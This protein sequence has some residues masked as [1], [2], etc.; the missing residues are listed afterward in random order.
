MNK[1][2]SI[3]VIPVEWRFYAALFQPASRARLLF[4]VGLAA[5]QAAAA[6]PVVF[7]LRRIFDHAL[8]AG[9][10]RALS[11]AVA[12]V[13]TASLVQTG[14]ML[15]ARALT[16]D[17]VK[18][19]IARL[20]RDLV[21]RLLVLPRAF[22]LRADRGV[23]H[24]TVVQDTERLDDMSVVM[25]TQF[26]P[27]LVGSV[28]WV[29]VLAWLD[30]RLCLALLMLW[31]L[32]FFAVRRLRDW[33][34]ASVRAFHATFER[35][36]QS[37]LELLHRLDLTR[38]QAAESEET[39]SQHERIGALQRAGGAVAWAVTVHGAGY[40]IL[41]M[42]TGLVIL[43]I[44]GAAV[45]HGTLTVGA[46][47]S[48]FYIARALNAA[49]AQLVQLVPK[50]IAGQEA[51]GS[52]APLLADRS[53]AKNSP[54]T[55]PPYPKG[56]QPVHFAGSIEF[57]DVTFSY[58]TDVPD[59]GQHTPV[60]RGV[61]LQFRPG[62]IVALMGPNGA[63]K[64]TLLH[65]LLGFYRPTTG[66]IRADDQP[67]ASLDLARLRARLGV[68]PQSPLFFRGTVR[69]N[70]VY[71][72]PEAG[73]EDVRNALERAGAAEFV[74]A[75]PQGLETLIGDDGT[76]L[77]GGQRQRLALARALLRKPA[78]L[79]LDEPTTHLDAVAVDRLVDTLRAAERR[80][81]VLLIS[82]DHDLIARCCADR[83]YELRSGRLRPVQPAAEF[84]ARGRMQPDTP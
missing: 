38:Q 64:S 29:G 82:H 4:C 16:L 81:T 35:Y 54:F 22:H 37:T 48:A 66:E 69:E 6:W 55:A 63:G 44:G 3:F 10:L 26:V 68:V 49:Q 5:A 8:P 27:A 53:A 59:D 14:L 23:L 80:P 76:R 36:S 73:P 31:P 30:W 57:R 18:Q 56:G 12:G 33:M 40:E 67:Y 77:S 45:I 24:A 58:P 7:L 17:V 15:G 19:V 83:V 61:S 60:L 78:L 39:A 21:D 20:R 71:G 47:V 42:L 34:R 50:L 28:G 11:L 51:L 72:S 32:V 9:D 13:F 65:L 43:L 46:L 25:I 1:F 2:R 70:L 41:G 84:S 62:E 75:L 79:V 52:L 74:E